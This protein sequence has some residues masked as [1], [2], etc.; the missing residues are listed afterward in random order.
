MATIWSTSHPYHHAS[1]P[2]RL[3]RP[4]KRAVFA[5][6]S[7][8][9]PIHSPLF[10]VDVRSFCCDDSRCVSRS[11]MRVRS[12]APSPRQRWN[13]APAVRHMPVVR[14]TIIRR[15]D[16]TSFLNHRHLLKIEVFAGIARAHR[17]RCWCRNCRLYGCAPSPR[18][19]LVAARFFGGATGTNGD[20]CTDE[21]GL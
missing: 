11:R 6:R 18:R 13:R 4:K 10:D 16:E 1:L 12:S 2:M 19:R 21:G 15:H 3:N 14:Q 17:P 9:N 5:S 8:S 7:L 20:G